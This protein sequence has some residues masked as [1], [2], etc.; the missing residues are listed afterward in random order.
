MCFG[1]SSSRSLYEYDLH[2]NMRVLC[3]YA[4]DWHAS[5]WNVSHWNRV[6]VDASDWHAS[7]WIASGWHVIAQGLPL[8]QKPACMKC[9]YNR[10]N[11][12]S[13]SHI[14]ISSVISYSV[15]IELLWKKLLRIV[16]I[17]TKINKQNIQVKAHVGITF[18]SFILC[19]LWMTNV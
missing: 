14:T 17:C 9:L 18:Y 13:P 12:T 10:I 3:R 19:I 11:I 5:S 15:F 8:K 2:R 1:F 16:L 6:W 7:D 4:S